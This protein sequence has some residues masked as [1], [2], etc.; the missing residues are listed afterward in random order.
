M[1]VLPF[2]MHCSLASQA[3]LHLLGFGILGTRY[4]GRGEAT[5]RRNFVWELSITFACSPRNEAIKLPWILLELH[6]LRI[7]PQLPG[8]ADG[9]FDR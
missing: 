5:S 3:P 4:R 8:G 9:I 1:L 2:P 7:R 6:Q